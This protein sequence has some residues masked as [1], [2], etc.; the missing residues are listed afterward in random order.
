MK[1]LQNNDNTFTYTIIFII[2]I[3]LGLLTSCDIAN[4]RLQKFCNKCKEKDSINTQIINT[5]IDTF[6]Q[7]K[8]DSNLVKLYIECKNGKPQINTN[9]IDSNSSIKSNI[10]FT[11][12]TNNQTDNSNIQVIIKNKK[13]KDTIYIKVPCKSYITTRTITISKYHKIPFTKWETFFIQFGKIVLML[14]IFIIFGMILKQMIKE[15]KII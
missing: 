14:I 3:I 4:K 12:K 6:I 7:V 15:F 2:I 11:G 5:V 8:E 13:L 10:Q 1:H 9:I